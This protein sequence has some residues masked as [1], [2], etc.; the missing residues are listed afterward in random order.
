M[1]HLKQPEAPE[2]QLPYIKN[3]DG[4]SFTHTQISTEAESN[5]L[6]W[7]SYHSNTDEQQTHTHC[8]DTSVLLP[9]F[10]GDCR[11]CLL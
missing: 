6:T 1:L 11:Q 7:A 2:Y 4:V 10:P 3:Y 5:N 8:N 9:L